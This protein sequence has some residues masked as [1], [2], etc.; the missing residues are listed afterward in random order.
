MKN[1]SS[2]FTSKSPLS[3]LKKKIIGQDTGEIKTDKKGEYVIHEHSKDTIRPA[4][5]KNFKPFIKGK[6]SGKM[7]S[8]YLSDDDYT[9]KDGKLAPSMKQDSIKPMTKEMKDAGKVGGSGALGIIGGAGAAGAKAL[10]KAAAKAFAK[11]NPGVTLG[12]ATKNLPKGK[13]KP[14]TGKGKTHPIITG[15][16]SMKGFGG[17]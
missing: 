11:R 2:Q 10:G 13:G 16:R 4:N 14:R 9:V 5:N 1:F 17:R 7:D 6:Q 12:G 8:G 15:G 3:K